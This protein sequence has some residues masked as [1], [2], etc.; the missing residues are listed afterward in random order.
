MIRALFWLLALASI[1]VALALLGKVT[2]GYAIFV[3]SGHRIDM[4]FNAFVILLLIGYAALF[5]L[6]KSIA[7]LASL[8]ERVRMHREGKARQEARSRFYG[9]ITAYLE[10]HYAEALAASKA[11]MSQEETRALAILIAAKSAHA[12]GLASERDALLADA[13]QID[14]GSEL[15][16]L[17]V[18]ADLML[19]EGRFVDAQRALSEALK[20]DRD[21]GRAWLL[22]HECARGQK[23]WGEALA[24]LNEMQRLKTVSDDRIAELRQEALIKQIG[25]LPTAAEVLEAWRSEKPADR[26]RGRF[27]LAVADALIGMEGVAS[28]REVLE[29]VL[30]DGWNEGAAARWGDAAPD[31][32]SDV[33]VKMIERA[34]RWLLD[35]PRDGGLLLSLGKLCLK[36]GLPGKAR[37]YLEASLSVSTSAGLRAQAETL[38]QAKE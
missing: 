6:W 31:R 21:N 22:R 32:P 5:V 23:Q 19:K 33:T 14:S 12:Q 24:A 18:A 37:G 34:E 17:L 16:R 26:L 11:A 7:L 2:E 10:G 38:L 3:V 4:S 35:H 9:G 30:V 8:P 13:R 28:A 36:Q 1:A 29:A 25:T 27:A 15:S 20:Q